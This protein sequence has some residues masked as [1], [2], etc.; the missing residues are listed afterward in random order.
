MFCTHCGKSMRAGARFCSFCGRAQEAARPPGMAATR[1]KPKRSIPVILLALLLLAFAVSRLALGVVGAAATAVVT[2]VGQRI[3]VGAGQDD[4][5]TRDP[6]RYEVFYRFTAA[7]G[8][9]YSGSMTKNFPHG[10]QAAP[11]GTLQTLTVRY[12][13]MMPHIN[14]PDEE[15]SP[16]SGFILMGLAVPLFVLGIKGSIFIGIGKVRK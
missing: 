13:P 8:K 14:A 9:V 12:L 3:H 2:E 7:D 16:L 10:I 15:V 1:R 5:N 11:D 4:G 6:T